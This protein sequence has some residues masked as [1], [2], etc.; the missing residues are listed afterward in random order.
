MNHNDN[1]DDIFKR[2]LGNDAQ[3]EIPESFLNDINAKLDAL[4]KRKKRRALWF[5]LLPGLFIGS[6]I[7]Y[8]LNNNVDKKTTASTDRHTKVNKTTKNEKLAVALTA[9]KAK[10]QTEPEIKVNSST[11]KKEIAKTNT[12]NI[13]PNNNISNTPDLQ[14][15]DPSPRKNTSQ[16][17]RSKQFNT[18][19]NESDK[20]DIKENKSPVQSD[21]AIADDIHRKNN[22]LVKT[23]SIPVV[24]GT[25]PFERDTSGMLLEK[26]STPPNN[27]TTPSVVPPPAS[28]KNNSGKYSISLLGGT[29]YVMNTF[30]GDT[31]SAY[32]TKRKAE[33]KSIFGFDISAM[34]NMNINN[35]QLSTG[36]NYSEWGEKVNYSKITSKYPTY[37]ITYDSTTGDTTIIIGEGEEEMSPELGKYNRYHY[38]S[39]PLLIGYTIEMNKFSIIPK[40]GG[41]I[42]IPI[43][44][45]YGNYIGRDMGGLVTEKDNTIL[46]NFQSSIDLCYKIKKV[47]FIISPYYRRNIN[48]LVAKPDWRNSM[49]KMQT[50]NRYQSFGINFGVTFDL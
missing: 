13:D 40:I 49:Q 25:K 34:F 15:K 9:V 21:G 10:D 41:T 38:I 11:E 48:L 26:D 1:I 8:G 33:E 12:K 7:V 47:S 42:G 16:I 50:Q 35:W 44:N 22:D 36:F 37:T 19:S 45:K 2:S 28:T 17:D 4:E 18:I 39:I 30:P 29:Q 14:K 31:A 46:F 3:S 27:T 23:D 20:K 32:F 5:W 43:L 6:L 24:T